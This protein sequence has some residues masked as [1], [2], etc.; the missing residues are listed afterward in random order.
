VVD[1]K[2]KMQEA[3]KAAGHG[4]RKVQA[5]PSEM[6]FFFRVLELLQGICSTTGY[7]VRARVRT[8]ASPPCM[9]GHR[10]C[11]SGCIAG[12]HGTTIPPVS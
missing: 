1:R 6:V 2:K 7:L 4:A 12:A 8:L 3:N 9:R 10:G 5:F 11:P